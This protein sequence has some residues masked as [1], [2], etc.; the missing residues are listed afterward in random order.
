MGTLIIYKF[1]AD[2]YLQTM[3]S[4]QDKLQTLKSGQIHSDFKN[5]SL[6]M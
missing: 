2:L 3:H 4:F 5:A 1:S 6:K